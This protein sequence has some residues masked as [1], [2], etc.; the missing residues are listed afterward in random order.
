MTTPPSDDKKIKNKEKPKK[1]QFMKYG[2]VKFILLFLL[3]FLVIRIFF[4]CEFNKFLTYFDGFNMMNQFLIPLFFGALGGYCY[5]IIDSV[6]DTYR[7]GIKHIKKK[8]SFIGAIAGVTAVNLLNPSGSLS[9]VMILALIAGLSGFSYLKRN[10]LVDSHR[11]D[12]IMNEL[13]ADRK[14]LTTEE[15][16][17]SPSKEESPN[18]KIEDLYSTMFKMR[19]HLEDKK[20][21]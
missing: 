21:D 4:K 18:K 16:V 15:V 8:F 9:Q 10:A 19:K 13:K 20:K 6:K 3:V 11:E 5:V 17:V 7:Q 14:D 12:S 1:F 2:E